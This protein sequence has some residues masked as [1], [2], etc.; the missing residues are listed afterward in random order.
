VVSQ[1]KAASMGMLEQ[2]PAFGTVNMS[3]EGIDGLDVSW[4]PRF[5][6]LRSGLDLTTRVIFHRQLLEEHFAA[7]RREQDLDSNASFNEEEQ[8]A[9]DANGWNDWELESESGSDSSGG[10]QSVSS[11]SEHDIDFSDSD[12]DEAEKAKRRAR[13]GKGKAGEG[14]DEDVNM[15]AKSEG[16]ATDM[17]EGKKLSL[18][19]TQKVGSLGPRVV[20]RHSHGAQR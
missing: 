10:W 14:E 1:G 17:S 13:K 9:A 11:D 8:D 3:A 5:S 20:D 6:S 15:D 2:A 7:A 19:A 18:L 16:G 12:D 4:V